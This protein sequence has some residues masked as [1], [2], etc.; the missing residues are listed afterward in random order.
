MESIAGP[1]HCGWQSATMLFIVWPPGSGRTTQ[2]EGRLN[3]RDPQGVFGARYR[4]GLTR[5]VS[6]PA[7]ARSTGYRYGAIEIYLSPSDQ[8]QAIYV[9]SPGDAERWPRVDPIY[10]CA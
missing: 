1:S 6:L 2:F 10:L 9:V 5:N 4:D 8:H 7:D 3:I